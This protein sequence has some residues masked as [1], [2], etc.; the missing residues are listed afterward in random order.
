MECYSLKA[1]ERY[2]LKQ[3]GN[4]IFLPLQSSVLPSFQLSNNKSNFESSKRNF[5]LLAAELINYSANSTRFFQ[6]DK[7]LKRQG[8]D[9]EEDEEVENEDIDEEEVNHTH[10]AKTSSSSSSSLFRTIPTPSTSSSRSS[11]TDEKKL[12]YRGESRLKIRF[13]SFGRRG[14]LPQTFGK[15]RVGIIPDGLCGTHTLYKQPWKFEI[16]HGLA[17]GDHVC[18]T[19]RITNL[20]TMKRYEMTESLEES[21]IRQRRGRTISNQVFRAAIDDRVNELKALLLA[22]T[23]EVRKANLESLIKTLQPKQ[24]SEGLL[25]FG[26]Q[27]ACVQER[28]RAEEH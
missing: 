4:S 14:K 5:E 13:E 9:E 12:V 23:K 10:K 27:H 3:L 7:K 16:H 21:K 15:I 24:F 6:A 2:F 28:M 17:V 22:E 18:I 26:L 20:S 11:P 1:E 8:D 19:W 25:V